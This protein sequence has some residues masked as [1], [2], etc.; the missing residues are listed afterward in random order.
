MKVAVIGAGVIGV[1]TAYELSAQGHQVCVYEKNGAAA[2]ECSFGN[3]GITSPGYT[4]PWSN[5]GFTRHLLS[6]PWKNDKALRLVNPSIKDIRWFWQWSKANTSGNY[7]KNYEQILRLS[8]YSQYRKQSLTDTLRLE[9]ERSNGY[10][11]LLRGDQE[12]KQLQPSIQ[13]MRDAGLNF[14][15][16]T[17]E[18]A[19]IVEPALNPETPFS[20]AIQFPEDDVSNSRQFTL[21]LKAEAESLGAT[22]HFN[23]PVQPLSNAAPKTIRTEGNHTETFDAVVIC[24]GLASG[25][26]VKRLG[27][28]IPIGCISAYSISAAVRE[29]LDAPRSSV[30]DKRYNVSISRLGQRVRVS[31]GS[32]IG[33]R[34]SQ[35]QVSSIK[36]LYRVL[37]DWFPGAAKTQD[38]VQVWKGAQPTC[39][40]GLPILG[41]SGVRGIWLNVGHGSSGWALACGSAK[42]IADSMNGK[43]PDTELHGFSIDRLRS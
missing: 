31:G 33:G 5:L 22:F 38:S 43:N 37:D 16:L 18:E 11:V 35:H 20:Q 40:D 8:M 17:S 32:E 27:L 2:E 10:M 15:V 29:P 26:L 14:R 34:T 28:N 30:M 24:A 36:S 21:L 23:S 13:S 6:S 41:E 39:I 1:T 7:I 19:R 4:L 42:A 12:V 3:S 9:Y 25:N